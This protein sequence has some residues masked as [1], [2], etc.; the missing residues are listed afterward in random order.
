MY[1]LTRD[2]PRSRAGA[3]AERLAGTVPIRRCGAA[4]VKLCGALA[5]VLCAATLLATPATAGASV[6]LTWSAPSA[7]DPQAAGVALNRSA[8]P[9]ATQCTAVDGRGEAVTFN[10]Q[11]PHGVTTAIVSSHDLSGIACPS[12]SQC[13]VV[14]VNGEETT[15]DPHATAAGAPVVID[16]NGIPLGIACPS[17]TQCTAIDVN[18]QE[19]TFNPHSPATASLPKQI[20]PNHILIS[21]A[22][23]GGSTTWCVAVDT[24]GRVAAFD[25]TGRFSAQ[26]PVQIDPN[27]SASVEA[28]ACSPTPSSVQCA[29]VDSGAGAIAFTAPAD[30]AP[31]E[32]SSGTILQTKGGAT[33]PTGLSCA[34]DT[35][36]VA[37]DG[38]G[39]ESTFDPELPIGA[40]IP[41]DNGNA[42]SDVSC[43]DQNQC[44]A[45]DRDGQQVT[46]NPSSPGSPSVAPIDGH[47]NLVGLSC[48][49]AD[50]CTAVDI[51]G[52]EV[53]F[54]PGSS[55]IPTTANVDSGGGS[56]Y[57]VACPSSGQC[58]AV[59]SRGQEV[60]FDPAS[61]RNPS[62]TAVGRG[63][64]LFGIACPSATQCTAVD[65]NGQEVTF[66]PQAAGHASIAT[67]DYGHGLLAV[68]CPAVGQCSAVDDSG[69]E[70]TFDPRAAGATVAHLID[71]TPDSALACPTSTLCIAVDGAGD[72]VTFN[73]RAPSQA[74]ALAIDPNHQLTAVA[75]RAVAECVVVDA[76][77]LAREGDPRGTSAWS[78]RQL[79]ANPVSA[80][81]CPS[82]RE[83]VA[84]DRPGNAYLGSGGPLPPAPRGLSRPPVSGQALQGQVLK[85][86]R[87]RWLHAPTSYEYQWERCNRAGRRC[88]PIGGAT[89]STYR[90]TVADVGH[91]VRVSV[92]AW[93]IAGPGGPNGS[94][95]TGPVRL[96]LEVVR[97]T[98]SGVS[99]HAPRLVLALRS[100]SGALRIRR[101][102]VR[103]PAGL[104]VTGDH[105]L[106]VRTG[107]P[108]P[109]YATTTHGRTI[110]IALAAPTTILS[111]TIAWPGLTASWAHPPKQPQLQLSV[112]RQS[113]AG[114][115]LTLSLT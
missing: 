75:C 115:R 78:S 48:G 84:V 96:S 15:F 106:A 41:I 28:A 65:D 94:R 5:L 53:T 76:S 63:H 14:D 93:N 6:S 49:S 70:V 30:K 60:T 95:A 85:A 79:S 10:P 56:L 111:L 64:A 37:I 44:T 81:A 18:G 107:S 114:S 50:R 29:L 67:V 92:I 47:T 8:C 42:L 74:S 46:F 4:A 97:A 98:L 104:A 91:R 21:V 39:D 19:V 105:G 40:A 90:L 55:A 100:G 51:G 9:S 3:T 58:T 45:V 82:V 35:E 89:A 23:P 113:G 103:L 24:S 25:P 112:T 43:P 38:H 57:G 17:T 31:Q 77:G 22:C 72:E 101:I 13:T 87:G 11:S 108:R 80:L 88:R 66:N 12:T 86:G 27:T 61:P 59:D 26:P 62:L 1:W 20:D 99:R 83:C 109:S 33:V 32:G 36:C 16:P 52:S 54:A 69:A 110:A 73:P 34:A 68:A 102:V 2:I 71:R 7:V